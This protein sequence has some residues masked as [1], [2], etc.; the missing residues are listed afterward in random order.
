[1]SRTQLFSAPTL[2]ALV[3]FVCGSRAFAQSERGTIEG[4]VRDTSGAVVVGAKVTITETAT[5]TV[6]TSITTGA[7]EYTIPD[8]PVG[9]YTAEVTLQ[10]F[11]KGVISGLALHAGSTLRADVT[12]EVGATRESVEVQANALTVNAANAVMETSA[13]N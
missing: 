10:G 12:L 11:R 13:S 1:M 5:S 3:S 7:G 4:T 9:S 2:L 6:A 8:L